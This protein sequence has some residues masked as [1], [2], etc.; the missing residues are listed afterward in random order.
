MPEMIGKYLY[1][2]VVNEASILFIR[3]VVEFDKFEKEYSVSKR[4]RIKYEIEWG[5][6]AKHYGGIEI[7][8]YQSSRRYSSWYY[9]WDVAS[10]CVWDSSAIKEIRPLNKSQLSKDKKEVAR[11]QKE[12][13]SNNK[14]EGQPPMASSDDSR[15]STPK[16]E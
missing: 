7:C 2:V 8:P 10:G 5:E 4:A 14:N 15:P 6:V 1:E 12:E 11:R 3:N 16:F 13:Q 9:G